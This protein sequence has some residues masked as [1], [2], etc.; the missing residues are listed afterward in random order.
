ML[1]PVIWQH[2]SEQKIYLDK[3]RERNTKYDINQL[4]MYKI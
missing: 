4:E 3:T 1:S 2:T